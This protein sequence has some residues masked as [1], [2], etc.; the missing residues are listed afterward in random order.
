[1]IEPI[2]S[3]DPFGQQRPKLS[4]RERAQ[5]KHLEQQ[6]ERET[7]YQKLLDLCLLGEYDAARILARGH[8]EWGYEIRDGRVW[9]N[10]WKDD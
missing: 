6:R 7:G 5:Q 9:E 1:M 4:A 2:S 3:I 8:P 10:I